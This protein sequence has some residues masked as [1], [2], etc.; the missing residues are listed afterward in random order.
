MSS[1]INS[2]KKDPY[3]SMNEISWAK[4]INTN[5]TQADKVH[6]SQYATPHYDNLRASGY[7]DIADF[8]KNAN[9][10]WVD[11]FLQPEMLDALE[12]FTQ[13]KRLGE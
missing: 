12:R 8:Y 3:P 11:G 1:Y 4:K 9:D 13:F 5:G 7:G 2:Q 10:V 6:S